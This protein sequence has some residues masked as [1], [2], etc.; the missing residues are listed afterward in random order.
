MSVQ[1]IQEAREKL[2]LLQRKKAAY[3]HAMGLIYYDA[4]TSAPKGT[5]SN[6][7][8]TLTVLSEE[9]YKLSAG[10]ETVSLLESLEQNQDLLSQEE[11]RQVFLLLKEIRQIQKIPLDEYLTYQQLLVQADDVWHTAKEQSNFALFEPLLEKI[12]ETQKRF[13]FY[14]APDRDP[15]DFY[16]SEYEEGLSRESCDRFFATVKECLVPLLKKLKDCPPI[17]DHF[18]IGDFPEEKQEELAR[19]LMETMGLDSR[20]VGLASTEHPFTTSLGSHLDERI[21]THYYRDN[22]VSSLYSVVHEGGHAL[23][24]TGSRP[25]FAYTCLDGG[26]SMGIHES[27]SRLY[28]NIF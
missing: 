11:K 18:L 10:Q 27:Q 12:F 16:L 8:Q 22:F 3:N 7:E 6:R 19:Y 25:E 4:V 14:F 2:K 26:V 15:Y 9:A 24:D 1:T 23:Y 5:A 20:H 17:D 28:E 21:T 13:A